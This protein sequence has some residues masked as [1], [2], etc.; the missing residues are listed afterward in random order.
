[1]STHHS[2]LVFSFVFWTAT[3]SD[4]GWASPVR[5]LRNGKAY[6]DFFDE[7]IVDTQ[8]LSQAAVSEPQRPIS[9]PV[10]LSSLSMSHF[11]NHPPQSP[12][13][14]PLVNEDRVFLLVA[15]SRRVLALPS[16][17]LA[18][19]FFF[20]PQYIDGRVIPHPNDAPLVLCAVCQRWRNIALNTPKL[21]CSLFLT[22]RRDS[23]PR[24]FRLT[25]K[26]GPLYVE[27]CR[28]WLSRARS[29]PLSL[30]AMLSSV[31]EDILHSITDLIRSSSHQ[32]RD[33]SLGTGFSTSIF[34][35]DGQYPF[36]EK[37]SVETFPPAPI[38]SFR[39]APRLYSVF[40]PRYT[41]RIELPWKQITSFRTA[42]IDIEE[43]RELLRQVSNLVN[44]SFHIPTSGD[45]TLLADTIYLPKLR[46]LTLGEPYHTEARHGPA[47]QLTSI[48]MALF[49]GLKTPA[50]KNLAL[51][52]D[53]CE[54][55]ACDMAPFLSFVSQSPFQLRTLELSRIPTTVDGLLHCLN[56]TPTVTNLKLEISIHIPDLNPLFVEITGQRDFLP[57][58]EY[59]YIAPWRDPLPVMDRSLVLT[60]LLWR[61]LSA[62]VIRLKRFRFVVLQNH[63]E[64]FKSIESHRLY[65][66]LGALGAD[67]YVGKRSWEDAYLDL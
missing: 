15:V 13:S 59:L 47:A 54:L 56:A 50:L 40:F 33:I 19:I 34:P 67:F 60:A 36:L 9:P 21:W 55:G 5:T 38:L 31:P 3:D 48:P 58:L 25:A 28:S 20:C 17:I 43:C 53:C 24:P 63:K 4:T 45:L 52:T 65:R 7:A 27:L 11:P 57:K 10:T 42:S 29:V 39:D 22:S 37:L 30:C 14:V 6:G 2:S 61:F 8:E 62:E 41:S 66:V 1:M 23:G 32:W 12:N 26:A 35:V 18:E 46:S 44:A 51:G 16:E 49:A 64:Y